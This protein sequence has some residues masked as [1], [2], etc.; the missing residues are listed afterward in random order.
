MHWLAQIGLQNWQDFTS[1]GNVAWF[2][3]FT[4]SSPARVLEVR[5]KEFYWGI[6]NF[7]F[8]CYPCP[9]H[10]LQVKG[11]AKHGLPFPSEHLIC[12]CIWP[13]LCCSVG[14]FLICMQELLQLLVASHIC[15]L[16]VT[17]D[18]KSLENSWGHTDF[19]FSNALWWPLQ[20][21]TCLVGTLKKTL[22][23][24]QFHM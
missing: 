3:S 6:R 12:S 21:I 13:Y 18:K 10:M 24:L 22:T 9:M 19:K 20:P 14:N 7:C 4:V 23:K 8:L 11:Y 15:E 16:Q 1:L 5:R 2:I 17:A